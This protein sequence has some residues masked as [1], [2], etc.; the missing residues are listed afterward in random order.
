[1]KK[2]QPSV[3]ENLYSIGV[4]DKIERK[5]HLDYLS[6]AN[7]WALL[8]SQY[9]DAQRKVYEHDHTGLN[10]FTDGNTAYVKVGIIVNGIEHID[11]LPVM[12]HRNN[13]IPVAKV[14]STDVNKTI[15]RSTAKAIAMHGLGLSLWT[16]EDIADIPSEKVAVK[17]KVDPAG[18]ITLEK[19]TEDW[20]RVVKYIES[21]KG[22]GIEKIGQQLTRKYKITPS[23]K[24]EIVDMINS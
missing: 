2:E 15:Q 8:K 18:T 23:L 14:T 13:A 10:F 4:K 17:P 24:K 16:G 11:Y 21:N 1:M 9:P 7:A 3:F 22:L 5:G 6:W 20:E 12:D 19:D